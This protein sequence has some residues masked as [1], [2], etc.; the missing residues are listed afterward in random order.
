MHGEQIASV[1]GEGDVCGPV[2]TWSGPWKI[3]SDWWTETPAARE[4]WDV[5]LDGGAVYRVYQ[6][7]AR[8][9]FVDA[10]YE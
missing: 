6:S 9:W 4:Y 3:E 7:E 5:E 1:K 10:R 2:R 8:E